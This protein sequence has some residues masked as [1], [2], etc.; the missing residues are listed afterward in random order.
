MKPGLVLIALCAAVAAYA[1]DVPDLA[2]ERAER[3]RI[4]AERQHAQEVFAARERECRDRFAVTA[5]L[6]AARRDRRAALDRLRL[7][8][9][10]L[11]EVDRK[12]RAAQRIEE[13][14]SNVS[15]EEAKRRDIEQRQRAK[16]L[17]QAEAA[18]SAASAPEPPAAPAPRASAVAAQPHRAA[19]A[20]DPRK[21]QAYEQRQADAKAH[22]EA[23]ARRNAERAAKGKPANP[24]PTPGAASLPR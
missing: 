9:D 11:D 21:V 22:R 14:R 3:E 15:A 4:S 8:Q 7:Q 23:A 5:C 6:D 16:A 20:V 24:L 12:R 18:A 1:G 13:I 10:A 19:S 2:A 17:Q